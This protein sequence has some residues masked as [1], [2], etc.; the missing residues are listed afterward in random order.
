[1]YDLLFEKSWETLRG[2]AHNPEFLGANPG[3]IAILHTWDQQIKYHPHIHMIVPAGGLDKQIKWKNSKQDGEFLF[4]VKEMSKVFSARFVAKLRELDRKGEIKKTLPKDLIKKPWV[5][6]A[7]K[8]FGSPESVL[9]YLSRYTHRV[10][11]SNHRILNVTDKDVTFQ[12][13]DRTNGY[14]KRTE[15]ISGV[16]FVERFLEHI[17]PA[18]FRKIRYLG[19]LANRNKRKNIALIRTQFEQIVELGIKKTRS[20]ILK[21]LWGEQSHLHCKECGGEMVLVEN[22]PQKRAPPKLV[23]E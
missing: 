3:A 17:V 14:K 5:V 18:K 6:Y 22:Y 2:F 23:T 4:D 7:K 11:I 20:E 12:W 13:L 19:F 16:K 21:E 1:M 9:E 8:A 10:A 15:T